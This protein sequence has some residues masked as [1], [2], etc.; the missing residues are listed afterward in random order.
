M[1]GTSGPISAVQ[2][3][4][5][6]HFNMKVL[7]LFGLVAVALAGTTRFEGYVVDL[8]LSKKMY[9]F[10]CNICSQC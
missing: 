9:I 5:L 1:G 10:I 2:G 6:L 7:L 3:Q 8:C 4:D